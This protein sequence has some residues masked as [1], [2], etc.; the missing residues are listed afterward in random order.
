MTQE[1]KNPQS[2]IPELEPL[3]EKAKGYA[4]A[5]RHGI[6][7]RAPFPTATTQ[8]LRAPFNGALAK[9]GT[10][11]GDV[12]DQ[13]AAAADPGLMAV[14]SPNFFGW[15]MGSSHPVGVAADWMASAWGQNC[16]NEIVA[17]AGAIAEEVAGAWLLQALDLPA[18]SSV[19]FVTGATMANFVGLAAARSE[20]LRRIGYDVEAN[21]LFGAPKKVAVFIG[22][23]AHA[24]VFS[25]LQF[26]GIGSANVVKIPVDDNGAMRADVLREMVS[27]CFNP[28]IIVAQ[29]GQINT[30]AFDPFDEI[31]EIAAEH[32]AWVHVDGAFGLWARASKDRA[33]LARGLDKAD[34]WATD[35]HKWLQIPYDCGYVIV[36][37]A[38][39]HRRAMSIAASY[40]PTSEDDR[41]DPADYVPE[42][43]RRARGFAT[44]AVLKHLGRDG[45]D[46]LVTRHC[47]LARHLR[48]RLDGVPGME[49]LND[50][51][52]NQLAVGFG[53]GKALIEQNKLAKDMLTMM[54]D[55]NEF[56]LGGAEWHGRWI[57]RVSIISA[58]TRMRHIDALADAIIANW[59]QLN[60]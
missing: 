57:M 33:H 30:G 51:N 49:V 4:T 22:E 25:A 29:A 1:I 14:P 13:L 17:P 44:W 48:D 58:P 9:E 7:G 31:A 35:G 41:R 32:N 34:S 21:G 38:E 27:A 8:E 45:I 53:A 47:D 40:L 55:Q 12:I 3:L 6:E 18:Q 46:Q 19:G 16:A 20:V 43:S 50:V 2:K 59:Q 52:L 56:V 5:F 60:P 39:A 11:A 26:L 36:K 10:P 37:D 24:T 23:D 15:V 28:K 54:R 42:L